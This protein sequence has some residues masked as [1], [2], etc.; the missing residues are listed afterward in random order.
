MF[1]T[2]TYKLTLFVTL[3]VTLLTGMASFS[4]IQYLAE[5]RNQQQ[6]LQL[7]DQARSYAGVIEQEL[8]STA[9][10]VYAIAGWLKLQQGSTHGFE[11]YAAEIF[12]YYPHVTAMSLAPAGIVSAV[13]P[14]SGGHNLLGHNIFSDPVQRHA[15]QSIIHSQQV[16]LTGPYQL[17]QGGTGIVARLPVNLNGKGEDAFWGFVNVT[18]HLQKMRSLA[19]LQQLPTRG[20]Q[21]AL[22]QQAPTDAELTLIAGNPLPASEY[23]INTVIL[24]DSANW[25]LYLY[26]GNSWLN[27][28]VLYRQASLAALF[29]ALMALL[30]FL[31]MQALDRKRQL[32]LLVADKTRDL[33]TQLTRH[34][35][36]IVASN[37]ASWEY[38]PS[39]RTLSCSP[40]YF[41]MLGLPKPERD[42]TT[43]SVDILWQ[44]LLHPADLAQAMLT[45]TQYLQRKDNTLYESTF[46][47]RH[48]SGHWVWILSRGRCIQTDTAKTLMIGT[49][50][51]IT[52]RKEVELQLQLLARLFEQSS[53]G[54]VITNEQQQ[55]VQVN[56]A[57]CQIS[58]YKHDEV[59]GK[60]PR[61]LSSGRHDKNFYNAMWQA[62]NSLGSWKGEIWNRRKDGSIYPEW[63]SISKIAGVEPG[64]TYYVGLFSDISQYKEDE[65]Q[66]R[67]LA[68]FD[69]LTALPNRVLLID[70]TERAIAQSKNA[71]QS[72]VMLV[73]DIDRFKHINDSLGHQAGDELLVQ[74]ANRL[75]THCREQDT[76]S[77]LNSDE[78]VMLRPD[79]DGTAAAIL[80][81]Q[82][83]Q[84]IL[85]PCL[86]QGHELVLSASVGIA[87]YPHDG[88]NFN[89]LYKHADIAMYQAKE[90]GR[91]TYCFF[92]PQMQKY[93]TRHL[94]L[95]NALRRAVER[96][97]LQLVYQPQMSLHN[98]QLIGF[99]VLLRWHNPE[100]GTISPAEFIPLAESSGLIVPIGDWVLSKALT[101][102]AEWRAEG[103]NQ[104][105]I[106]INLSPLQFRQTDLLAKLEQLLAQHQLPATTVELEITESAM[107]DDPAAAAHLITQFSDKGCKIAIDDFGTGYSSLGYLK[108]FSL[109]KLKIDQSFIRDLLTDA[110]DKA[111]VSA[112]ISMAKSL[113]LTTIAEGVETLEQQQMLHQLGCDDIQGYFYSKPLNRKDATAFIRSHI[114]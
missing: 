73:I 41:V 77:R 74:L 59:I 14:A 27:Q 66:I 20:I 32:S 63:L 97:E 106:A 104:I 105:T 33:Q 64:E 108:R 102:L 43:D 72:L 45:F 75:K 83:L 28:N 22:L 11:R 16:Q 88:Q 103:Y 82:L 51:D 58:G 8:V 84:H 79:T 17:V 68:E 23:S 7:A 70:R 91:N 69:T 92:T 100:L 9:A 55:I 21:Y 81:E 12:P 86:I 39:Q 54:L 56:Q 49:H 19:Q 93:H 67:F 60:D 85:Q 99:E 61:L 6:K 57:F 71:Q 25:I 48:Q 107:M 53:E 29:T 15:A 10:A 13:Y 2:K 35:S 111:I 36:F 87:L 18:F 4:L 47:M 30:S 46:R 62:I 90:H 37:T 101:Q 113:E 3:L 78:F 65:A 24:A 5:Q 42:I 109:S 40:E 76:L 95:E 34:R 1:L 98:Q 114:F 110:D 50:I 96:E 112:I 26:P 38:D 44:D 89:E 94:L 52:E 31:L 80:A